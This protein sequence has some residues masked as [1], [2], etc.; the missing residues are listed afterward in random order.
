MEILAINT[1]L[2]TH[3]LALI[4]IGIMA[5]LTTALAGGAVINLV[6]HRGFI[7]VVWVIGFATVASLFSA[8][9]VSTIQEGPEVTYRAKVTDF[10]E[11]YEKGY[12][13]VGR[14]GAIYLLQKTKE[15]EK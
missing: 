15:G 1:H 7:N 2:L 14:N 8:A 12:E 6:E 10:N 13:V 5:L 3:I 11:V 4:V 9:M